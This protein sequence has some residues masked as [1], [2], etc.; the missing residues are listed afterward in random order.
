LF[1]AYP[2]QREEGVR[3]VEHQEATACGFGVQAVAGKVG[4]DVQS[5]PDGGRAV[6]DSADEAVPEGGM[7]IA[8]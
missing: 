2:S 4:I 7:D 8:D 6:A 1:L 5:Q 3:P